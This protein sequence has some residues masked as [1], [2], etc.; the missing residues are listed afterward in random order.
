MKPII[1]GGTPEMV[2]MLSNALTMAGIP[3]PPSQTTTDLSAIEALMSSTDQ[4]TTIFW[5]VSG[6]Q[7]EAEVTIRTLSRNP[8]AVVVAT[9]TADDSRAILGLLR[10]GAQ[11]YLD[12]RGDLQHELK[13]LLGRRSSNDDGA[14]RG[15]IITVTSC[16]GGGGATTIATNL[17]AVLANNVGNCALIDLHPFGGD[18]PAI[19]KLQPDFTLHELAKKGNALDAAL[20]HKSL[21]QHG[22]GISVLTSPEPFSQTTP[23]CKD[24]V[25]RILSIAKSEFPFVVVDG[26]DTFHPE[27]VVALQDCDDLVLV[28][29][30]DF[31]SLVRVQ[32]SI[33]H[34]TKVVNIPASSIHLV[35]ARYGQ[36]SEL[37]IER[38][39]EVLGHP[40]AARIPN[41]PSRA[42]SA[43]NMGVPVVTEFPNSELANSIR[44]LSRQVMGEQSP[45]GAPKRTTF[46]HLIGKVASAMGVLPI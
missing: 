46:Q 43:I 8:N 22:S 1:A 24:T 7:E 19:L 27:Q 28:L 35:A 42:L 5:I 20:L 11:D 9:G 44:R 45:I 26:E 2:F 29:R 6:S 30:L 25:R 23:L 18:L 41:D 15:R 10:A 32:K 33:E 3:C 34:L 4:K 36:P 13:D 12:I 21:V 38:A 14:N 40:L 17:A 37:S 16:G 39:E 31:A